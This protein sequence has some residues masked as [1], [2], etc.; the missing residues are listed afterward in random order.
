MS[1]EKQDNV[2]ALSGWVSLQLPQ[3]ENMQFFSL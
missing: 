3:Y 1:A 2:L